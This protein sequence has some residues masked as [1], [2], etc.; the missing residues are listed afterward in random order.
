MSDP[1]LIAIELENFRGFVRGERLDLDADAILVRGEN[2]SGKTSLID[3]FLWLFCG[4]LQY[5]EARVQKLRRDEDVVRSRFAAGAARVTL[6]VESDGHRFAFTRTGDQKETTLE[7]TSDGRPVAAAEYA[8]ANLFGHPSPD[9]LQA[10]VLTWGLLRQDAVRATLDIAGGALHERLAAIVGLEQVSG[11]ATA[12]SRAARNLLTER[13]ALRKALASLEERHAEAVKRERVAAEELA[14]GQRTAEPLESELRRLAEQLPLG[15]RL[16]VPDGATL[17]IV[18]HIGRSFRDVSTALAALSQRRRLWQEHVHTTP[19]RVEDAERAVAMARTEVDAA[20]RAGPATVQL[21][22]AALDVLDGDVCPVCGQ[23]V[24]SAML[25]SS[26]KATLDKS[27]QLFSAAQEASDALARANSRLSAAREHQAAVARLEADVRALEDN[28]RRAVAAV[29]GLAYDG[30]LPVDPVEVEIA[31]QMFDRV[32]E[33]MREVW[34]AASVTGSAHVSRLAGETAAI[35]D[36]LMSAT[37]NLEH[38]HRRYGRAK[39]LEQAAHAAAQSIVADALAQLEPSFAE[40]FDRLDPNPAFS[41]LRARQDIMR[42]INQVVPVV[43]D[44]KRGLEANPLLV[45][46]EGQLNVVA[47]SYFFGMALN[48]G[49]AMLP[50][51]ILDDPLQALDTIAVLGFG[52]LCRRI[53]EERQLIV[54]THDR[55]YADILLRKLSPRDDDVRL[56]VHDLEGWTRQGPSVHPS[57]PEPARIASL[58]HRQAS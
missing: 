36:E 3:G 47:L 7:A 31:A 13:T 11:F 28:V 23:E 49:D 29:E 27:E 54:T 10:A 46:S 37:A 12:T 8:L 32:I 18:E 57:R 9:S 1:R 34:R 15:C 19:E 2:G 5:L 21:A 17:A 45:F 20:G 42:N 33:D 26:L 41:E 53:R 14:A 16:T 51:L 24:D 38:L 48:A 43:R 35:A 56:I 25:I 4:R 58:V 50:F 55:R 39:I 30:V 22:R 6:E 40:V 44:T 52:D